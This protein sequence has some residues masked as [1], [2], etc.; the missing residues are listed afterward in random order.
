[1]V[2][3]L[4]PEWRIGDLVLTNYP[5]MVPFGSDYGTPDT[6]PEVLTSFLT[7]GDIELT[8]R[9][10]N[11]TLTIP[12]MI[13]A[14]DLAAAAAYEVALQ[15]ECD[16]PL[17]T[18]Y[19][20]PGDGFGEPFQFTVFRGKATF[21]RDD[22]REV[23]GYRLWSL[24]WRALSWPEAV[25][26][27]VVS[28]LGASGT[29]T[30]PVDTMSSAT[31]WNGAIDGTVTPTSSGG[32]LTLSSATGVTGIRTL[33]LTRT[34][35]IDTASTKYLVLDW[36]VG[37]GVSY[38]SG[39]TATADGQPLTVLASQASPTTGYTRTWFVV[40]AASVNSVTFS[41]TTEVVP[42]WSPVPRSLMLDNLARTDV[43]PS[44]GSPRQQVNML[45]ING[46]APT[47]GSIAVSHSSSALGQ[48]LVYTYPDDGSSYA[49]PCRNY[50][51]GGTSSADADAVSG[52]STNLGAGNNAQ[53]AVPASATPS[54][55]YLVV[56]RLRFSSG[57][58]QAQATFKTIC[59]PQLGGIGLTPETTDI[60]TT[61]VFTQK[62]LF[63]NI[64]FLHLPM[65]EMPLNPL[66]VTVLGI[67]QT[68][69]PG[70]RDLVLDELYLFNLAG[71]LSR[72]NCGSSTPTTGAA[73]NRL[74]IDSPSVDNQGLGRYV[75]G[76]KADR[77]D[78]YSALTSSF[79]DPAVHNLR[80]GVVK[81]FTV[82]SN[83][84]TSA[85]LAYRF[86]PAGHSS[87]YTGA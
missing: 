81:I 35:A 65:V 84:T 41:V 63:V 37:S 39:I 13:E 38:L 16:K 48:V 43:R 56:A 28:P 83:P 11:R 59:Y 15:L 31:G 54:G 72:F 34:G 24:E 23:A 47:H 14:S 71:R 36:A 68:S 78:A 42:P 29:T 46:S 61:A 60:F 62:Y 21:Q 32:V 30:T 25:E 12:V 77:S 5:Y 20:D 57:V 82:T 9:V 70:G 22:D 87:V 49:P 51:V 6:S 10:G 8:S 86:R 18:L 3:G 1:M 53:Y 73:A 50:L 69:A 7:D 2:S 67:V 66:A 79:S 85:D 80:P 52:S 74:W 17:N 40:R 44:L 33:S 26:E 64:G 4:A 76:T 58:G 75:M 19:C 55:E 45:P 27:V